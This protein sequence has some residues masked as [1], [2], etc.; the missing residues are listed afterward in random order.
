MAASN[1]KSY[2]IFKRENGVKQY[3][4]YTSL[5]GI[6]FTSPDIEQAKVFEDGNKMR[7]FVNAL[8]RQNGF[9]IWWNE[10]IAI[11]KTNQS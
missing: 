11:N 8:N 1:N 5:V 7:Q 6:H 3:F 4:S 2:V 9:R 10:P